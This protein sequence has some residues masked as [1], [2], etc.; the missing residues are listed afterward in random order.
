VLA[1]DV[2]SLNAFMRLPASYCHIAPSVAAATDGT[3]AI[4]QRRRADFTA[5]QESSIMPHLADVT[6]SELT[7]FSIFMRP[8]RKR[9][10]RTTCNHW[11][12]SVCCY[13]IS[14]E[15]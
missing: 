14:R 1:N 3:R 12:M 10:Y 4:C 5:S 2:A 11:A 13:Y 6:C 8:W 15:S 9:H 7:L